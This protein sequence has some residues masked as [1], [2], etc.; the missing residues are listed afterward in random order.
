M[1]KASSYIFFSKFNQLRITLVI[2]T[3]E[4]QYSTDFNIIIYT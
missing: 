2:Q 4:N 1:K 3:D